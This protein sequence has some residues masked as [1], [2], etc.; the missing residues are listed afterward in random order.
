MTQ[1]IWTADD[2]ELAGWSI[3]NSMPCVAD[4]AI[5]RGQFVRV[6]GDNDGV[7]VVHVAEF[8]NENI[9]GV[10]LNPADD[11][12]S[13]IVRYSGPTDVLSEE[14]VSFYIGQMVAIQNGWAIPTGSQDFGVGCA[15]TLPVVDGGMMRI[16]LKVPPNYID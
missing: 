15:L 3:E 6:S 14:G 7:P 5:A 2:N 4:G 13:V 9:V 11:G 16:M 12:D 10:A 1:R 8:S